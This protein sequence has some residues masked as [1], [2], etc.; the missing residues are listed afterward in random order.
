MMRVL[1][2]TG[3]Q[4][5]WGRDILVAPVVE[6]GATSRRVYLPRGTWFDFWTE[7]TLDGGRDITRP[8]DLD[9]M[10]LYVRAGAVIPLDPVRQ[11]SG[12]QVEAPMTLVVFPGADGQ[13]AWYD[14]DG[15]SFEHERGDFSLVELT[16][17]DSART[18]DLSLAPGSRVA[19]QR[20]RDLDVRI[21][22][23][24]SKQS[25]R[26]EGAPLRITF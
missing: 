12:E 8:V 11:Y 16:W 23:T 2:P 26:F 4:Y 24:T 19:G 14:D 6:K 25:I 13:S 18:L 15:I 1:Q 21:A 9:T 3:D 22:G 5:F 10:P 7:E 20:P 17:Q